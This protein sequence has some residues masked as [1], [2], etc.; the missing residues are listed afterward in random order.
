MRK[1]RHANGASDHRSDSGFTIAELL[2]SAAI[3]AMLVSLLLT[4]VTQ[5]SKTWK[6]TSGKI[7]E[8]RD[9]RDA[10]DSITRRIS[11]ATLN[12]Y[13]DYVYSSN[14][15]P[16]AYMRQSELRFLSGPTASIL[17]N[18]TLAN[19][20]W[21]GMSVFFQAP[22]GFSTNSSNSILQSA[23][24]TWGYFIEYAS[25]SN[26]MPS[27]VSA[28]PRYRYRLMELM[29]PTENLSIYNYTSGG[30]ASKYTGID[31]V[32]NS[33]MMTTNRPVHVLAEN[34]IALILL[35]KLSPSDMGTNALH[36]NVYSP[37]SLAPYY[38]YDS[39]TNLNS[40]SNYPDSAYLNTHNQL[41]PVVQV[42]LVAVDETSAIRYANA[43]QN[44]SNTISGYFSNASSFD[45]DLRQLQTNL[46]T[47]NINFRVFTTD[48]MMRGAKW[49]GNQTN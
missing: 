21:P 9:A 49:S 16:T 20:S 17:S 13:L 27:F 32:T 23:L 46:A 47:N 41:P 5:T 28:K 40:S 30:A 48:V 3:L 45:S 12:S 25:D 10:F 24:N 11:Q 7:E 29:E 18:A 19:Y 26:S 6:S 36:S 14:G 8:F 43:Y 39:S 4:M 35:P 42:T 37:S 22:N 44:I 31:W 2:V 15:V 1:N 38:L 33:M 34:I